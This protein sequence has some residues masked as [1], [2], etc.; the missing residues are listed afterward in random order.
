VSHRFIKFATHTL[1]RRV[2]LYLVM[3]SFSLGFVMT[4]AG[5]CR[6]LRVSDRMI[7][8]AYGNCQRAE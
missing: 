8:S 7:M 3:P 6:Q 2:T 1:T 5:I 4:T